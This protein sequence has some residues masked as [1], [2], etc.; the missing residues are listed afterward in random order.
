MLPYPKSSFNVPEIQPP[1]ESETDLLPM[2]PL[3][4]GLAEVLISE[5]GEPELTLGLIDYSGD[6]PRL[7]DELKVGV[8]MPPNRTQAC[9]VWVCKKDDEANNGHASDFYQVPY[10]E[11]ATRLLEK[12]RRYNENVNEYKLFIASIN[13]AQIRDWLEENG[14]L[15]L[16]REIINDLPDRTQENIPERNPPPVDLLSND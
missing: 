11:I 10:A 12:L 7:A 6:I 5:A 13:N 9:V 2:Y 16:S 8:F 3:L 4:P 1:K 14:T 15:A